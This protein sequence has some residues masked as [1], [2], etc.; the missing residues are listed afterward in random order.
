MLTPNLRLLAM[1]AMTVVL[2]PS[3]AHAQNKHDMSDM[4][5][6]ANRPDHQHSAQQHEGTPPPDLEIPPLPAGMT[7]EEVFDYSNSEPPS[8]FPDP[9]PD[10]QLFAFALFDQLEYRVPDDDDAR[11]RL[12]WEAEGWI[13]GDINKFW[14]KSEGEAIFEGTDEGESENDFLYSRLITPFWNVQTGVQYANEWITNDDYNDRWSYV[15]GLQGMA[16]YQ[17]ELDNSLYVSEDGDV[18][19][20]TEG[21]YDVRITQRLVLQP[22]VGLTFSAQTISERNLGS[23]LTEADFD[24]RLRY[25]IKRELAPY[26]G[27]RYHSLVGETENIA[28]AAGERTEQWLFLAGLRLAF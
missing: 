10:D 15:L 27:L 5:S 19:F 28:E 25:E 4:P 6:T 16:P 26:V 2:V 3:A 14:W 13:G 11:D 8:D 20:E 23:G 12:G 21:E 24:L 17:F 9:V 18:T 7:L 1:I 22:R